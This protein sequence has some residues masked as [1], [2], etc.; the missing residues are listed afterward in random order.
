M[1][2]DRWADYPRVAEARL[3]LERLL[4]MLERERMPGMVID[5]DSSTGKTRIVC[6][7]QHG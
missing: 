1:Q 3:R 5:G 4:G 2:R 7:F 6:K